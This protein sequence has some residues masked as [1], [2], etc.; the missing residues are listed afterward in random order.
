[1]EDVATV[2][3]F[4]PGYIETVWTDFLQGQM[5]AVRSRL[6]DETRALSRTIEADLLGLL[7]DRGASLGGIFRELDPAGDGFHAFVMP[8]R[9]KHHASG[10][11]KGLSLHGYIMLIFDPP[12]GLLS[13]AASQ[14]VRRMYQGGIASSDKEAIAEAAAIAVRELERGVQDRIE[15]QFEQLTAELQE[16]IGSLYREGAERIDEYLEESMARRQDTEARI[17]EIETLTGDTIPR[18]RRRLEERDR[19]RVA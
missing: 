2:R 14:I 11:A 7:G 8:K 13:L 4:L 6:Q 15:Q 19:C 1:V 5:I 16:E 17:D 12:L 18:L 10:V 3:R 9:G